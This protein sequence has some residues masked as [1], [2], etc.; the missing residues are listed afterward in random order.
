MFFGKFDL[1]QF[2]KTEL[3]K[4]VQKSFID[5]HIA[6]NGISALSSSVSKKALNAKSRAADGI[7]MGEQL[8]GE[9]IPIIY[10]YVGMTNQQFD[11]GQKPSE[12]DTE[13]TTQQVRIAVSEGPIIGMSKPQGNSLYNF[14][15]IIPS[16][17]YNPEH[18]Y[19]VR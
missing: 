7:A 5:N 19:T 17:S 13:K 12:V 2:V 1:G 11:E 15:K 8:N 10:G 3:T 16:T 18:H 14:E 9:F 6:R 4:Q